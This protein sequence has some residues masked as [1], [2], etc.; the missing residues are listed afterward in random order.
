[1]SPVVAL[2]GPPSSSA[3]APLLG[4]KRTSSAWPTSPFI[5][6][7]TWSAQSSAAQQADDEAATD[8]EEIAAERNLQSPLRQRMRGAHAERR[9]QQRGRHHHQ[10]ADQRDV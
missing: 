6:T 3:F 4:Y 8:N 7:R 1:M 5:G 2:L 9:C 10:R